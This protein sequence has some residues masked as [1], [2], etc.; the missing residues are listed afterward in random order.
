MGLAHARSG[1]TDDRSLNNLPDVAEALRQRIPNVTSVRLLPLHDMSF[2]DQVTAVREAEVLV[3]VHGAGLTH[4]VFMD[5]DTHVVEFQMNLNFFVHL[6]EC[7][8]GQLTLHQIPFRSGSVPDFILNQHLL[9]TFAKIY[10][11]NT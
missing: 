6:A 2:R 10:G 7:K 5:Q 11:L 3:G 9:P 1:V 4:L 8:F